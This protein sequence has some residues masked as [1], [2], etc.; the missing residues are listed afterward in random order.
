MGL[1]VK[2][3]SV[4]FGGVAALSNVSLDAEAG[5]ITG[6]IGPNGAGK[7]TLFNVVTGMQRRAEGT[8]RLDGRDL[9][10]LPPHRRSRLGLGRTFQRLELFGTLTARENIAVAA[11]M[12]HRRSV[13][14][15]RYGTTDEAADILLEKLG[16]VPVADMRADS[17]PTGTGRL[18]ELGRALAVRPRVLLLDEPASGQNAEETLRFAEI[19]R[20]LAGDGLAV[21]LVEHDMDLVMG[22]CDQVVVLDHGLVI[23]AGE[24]SFVQDDPAVQEAY[25]GAMSETAS[26]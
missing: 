16:L 1:E 6:L 9:G 22:V 23:S 14:T 26:G 3:V 10:R 12:S 18:V 21:L 25:L 7:T 19:L 13:G 20:S 4:H 2:D 15:D 11:S 5:L 24:P 17:L 8:V